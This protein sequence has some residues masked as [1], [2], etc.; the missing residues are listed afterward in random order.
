MNNNCNVCNLDKESCNCE[1]GNCINCG[2]NKA[3]CSNGICKFSPETKK[4]KKCLLC[5][6]NNNCFVCSETKKKCFLKKIIKFLVFFFVIYILIYFSIKTYANFTTTNTISIVGVGEMKAIPN[7]STINFT[8]REEGDSL[9]NMKELKD[10]VSSKL[11]KVLTELKNL[12]IENKDIK[13]NNYSFNPK[14]DYSNGRS[15]I[16]GYEASQNI[17]I[18]IRNI[19]DINNVLN[20]LA[21]NKIREVVGPNFEIDNKIELKEE[22]R[23]LAIKD[24]KEKAE[25]LSKELN[26]KIKRI[27][28]YSDDSQDDFGPFGKGQMYSG[29]GMEM[30][31]MTDTGIPQGENSVKVNAYLMFQI[32][33]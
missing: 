13:T 14:Y 8:I 20:I 12:D 30:G 27:V 18:K 19:D 6:G 11:D 2:G 31:G 9:V 10:K 4:E 5:N 3:I 22:A 15:N 17:D 29:T 24:A 16:F 21:E 32:E 33:N 1:N 25:K 23:E 7:I 26:V 28:G